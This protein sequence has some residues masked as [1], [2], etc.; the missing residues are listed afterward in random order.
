MHEDGSTDVGTA[1][2][3]NQPDMR[4][5]DFLHRCWR[6]QYVSEGRR[7][8][9]DVPLERSTRS[10]PGIYSIDF[11]NR[12]G[13]A[14]GSKVDSRTNVVSMRPFTVQLLLQLELSARPLHER[15]E[16]QD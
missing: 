14:Y 2:A 11:N 13:T 3:Q 15:G 16:P 6:V 12:Q 8:P 7:P 1:T 9:E 5:R 4:G 10:C